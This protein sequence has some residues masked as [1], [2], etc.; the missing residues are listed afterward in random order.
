MSQ[1]LVAVAGAGGYVGNALCQAFE[2]SPVFE[3]VRVTRENY[4][5]M[6]GRNYDFLINCAMPSKRFWAKNNPAADFEETVRKTAEL[7]YGWKYGKF[8]QI[9]TVSAR[10]E[11]ET[12]Y[13][14]HKAA[15]EKICESGENLI[16]RLTAMYDEALSKG[17]L[18]DILNHRKVFVSGKSRYAFTPL[19]FA[20]Q[21]IAGHLEEKGVVEVGAKNTVSLEEISETL[22][23]KIEFEGPVESQA[24]LNSRP[25]FPDA[26]DVFQFLNK[27]KGARS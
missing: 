9:S 25:E 23:E 8:I 14:R 16:V 12:V 18:V 2:E 17:A 20:G 5:A 7:V 27:M 4:A 26:R 11:L 15:A 21:W 3:V 13:G 24:I 10:C 6:Q 19:S 22:G 1:P